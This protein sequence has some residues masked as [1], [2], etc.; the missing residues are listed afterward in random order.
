MHT[1]PI[2][3]PDV[4]TF[5]ELLEYCGEWLPEMTG[6]NGEPSTPGVDPRYIPDEPVKSWR[7]D[8]SRV[9]NEIGPFCTIDL[10]QLG[11]PKHRSIVVR[12]TDAVLE[13]V[14]PRI[15]T[16][17]DHLSFRL[18]GHKHTGRVLVV[19]QHGHISGSHWLAEIDPATIPEYPFAARDARWTELTGAL[20][21]AGKTPFRRDLPGGALELTTR[22]D[23]S[24]RA[25]V[26]A[27]GT[28]ELTWPDGSKSR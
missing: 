8:G 13:A 23:P 3:L 7:N 2:L 12:A 11:G 22:D 24:I 9:Q 18:I 6:R 20:R 28:S 19:L 21:D 25:I 17:D 16:D 27:D 1:P 15:V 4:H 10:S 14:A 26:N 5:G